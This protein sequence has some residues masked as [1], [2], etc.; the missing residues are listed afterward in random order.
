[1]EELVVN[2]ANL[3]QTLQTLEQKM[4]T[5]SATAAIT[6]SP[7]DVNVDYHD[8]LGK[9][10]THALQALSLSPVPPPSLHAHT[11]DV[12][13]NSAPGAG[14]RLA[15]NGV[16]LLKA[17]HEAV[18]APATAEFKLAEWR[19][20]ARRDLHNQLNQ[21]LV[22]HRTQLGVCQQQAQE[23]EHLV[24]TQCTQNTKPSKNHDK[25]VVAR[26]LLLS[27][28]GSKDVPSGQIQQRV[29]RLDAVLH[30]PKLEAA[31]WRDQTLRNIKQQLVANVD[32]LKVETRQALEHAIQRATRVDGE[33]AARLR[34][35]GAAKSQM[36]K[37]VADALEKEQDPELLQDVGYLQ[38]RDRAQDAVRQLQAETHRLYQIM[39]E[40]NNIT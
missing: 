25:L 40:A 30:A 9:M 24:K 37:G 3:D 2:T 15:P 18:V 8:Q 13:K 22:R 31:A 26:R 5:R 14:T 38:A 11:H 23:R 1:M 17:H 4:D 19:S 29:V 35:V 27:G 10:Y 12:A 32:R 33:M 21:L 28:G 16:T 20:N 39:K 36:W 6:P 7:P 34:S